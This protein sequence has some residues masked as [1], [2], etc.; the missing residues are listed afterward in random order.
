MFHFPPRH[1]RRRRWLR[2]LAWIA[3]IAVVV[4]A[5]L[6]VALWL[7]VRSQWFHRKMV[8][9]AGQQASAALHTRVQLRNYNLHFSLTAPSLD[10]Y[11]ITVAGAPPYPSPPLLRI[12]HLHVGLQILSLL[13]RQWK[14]NDVV[15]DR[16]VAHVFFAASGANNLPNFSSGKSS[17]GS[18]NIFQMGIRRAAV[19]QGVVWYNNRAQLLSARLQGVS[20]QAAFQPARRAYAGSFGYRSGVL[21]YGA[22]RPLASNLAVQFD[23]T[24]ARLKLMP[25]TLASPVLQLRLAATLRNYA[26]PAVAGVYRLQLNAG[27]LRSTLRNS[28]LPSGAVTLAG[29]LDYA[30]RPGRSLWQSLRVIGS[31][32]SPALIE[33]ADGKRIALRRLR[34]RYRLVNDN[35]ELSGLHARLLGGTLDARLRMLKLGSRRG[36]G[37]ATLRARGQQ[38]GRLLTTAAGPRAN[39]VA[40]ARLRGS[41]ALQAVADWRGRFHDL[42]ARLDAGLRASLLNPAAGARGAASLAPVTASLHARYD[43]RRR[44]L[45][46]SRSYLD[47]PGNVLRAAGV[48]GLNRG[49]AAHM[50]IAFNS[51][52]LHEL[53]TLASLLRQA[54]G[55]PQPAPLGLYGQARFAGSIAGTLSRPRLSGSLAASRLRLRGTAWRTLAASIYASPSRLQISRARLVAAGPGRLDFSIAAGL[56]QWG[57]SASSP[58]QANLSAAQFQLASLARLAGFS[59]PL[60]GN[61][62]ARLAVRGSLRNPVGSGTIGVTAGA[63]KTSRLREPIQQLQVA[64]QGDGARVT[65]RARLRMAA[66]VADLTGEYRPHRQTYSVV[67]SANRFDLAKLHAA[68]GLGLAGVVNLNGAGQG[69]VANPEFHA[70][71]SAPG[72]AVAH[73]AI[74]PLTLQAS[75]ANHVLQAALDARA[76]GAWMRGRL[77]LSLLGNEPLTAGLDTQTVPLGP[78]IA[79]YSA[80]LAGSV[81]GVTEIHASLAGPL[82]QPEKM[83]AQVAIPVF[84]L[85]YRNRV[86]LA[87]AAPLRASLAHGRLTIESAHLE[88]TGTNLELNGSMPLKG[89]SGMAMRLIGA[90]DLRVAEIVDPALIG[91]GGLQLALD[92]GGSLASPKLGG[93]IRIVD[94]ALRTNSMPLGLAHA[95]GVLT[96][97]PHRLIVSSFRGDVGGGQLTASGGLTYRPALYLDLGMAGSYIS[98]L[99]PR[100]LRETF[101]GNLSLTGNLQAAMLAGQIKVYRI[102]ATPQFDLTTL[103]GQVGGSSAPSPPGSFSQ[104]L[105]LD[106]R[107]TTP[108]GIGTSTPAFSMAGDANLMIQGTA[109]DPVV[110]GRMNINRGD[111]LFNGNRFLLQS[112]TLM[113]A[114][115]TRTVPTV[116]LSAD[117]TIQQYKLHLRFQG[118]ADQLRTQYTSSP[119]L[120][121][122]DI[123]NLLAFGQTTEASAANPTPG[124]LG[125]ENMLAS[126]VA[127]QVT[128]R[129][130]K[131]AGISQLSVD[132]ILGGNGQNP[133]ARVNIRQRVTGNLYITLS[134]DVTSTQSDMIEI[135]YNFTPKKSVDVVRDQNGGFHINTRFKK[136]W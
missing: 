107:V 53:E 82:Q 42:R 66:G 7:V 133:G 100:E 91:S 130:Q 23:A 44:Q 4:I 59:I 25:L 122:A 15:V 49:R 124:S 115:P 40:Q 110:L 16:P 67:L 113:F 73:Q 5:A 12:A 30:S 76:E 125:A 120:P 85:N 131:I 63:I 72:L 10:V 18:S 62:N 65:A 2:I 21:Q 24:A 22:Y 39:R 78:L 94:A 38:L 104:N 14:L 112:G 70:S 50:T 34:G 127:S 114:N 128:G 27:R 35:F 105:Q 126:S 77:R 119:P 51:T 135:Q 33:R 52:N 83:Q 74:A 47:L 32:A 90:L 96:L 92:A 57:V 117:T 45:A 61:L 75:L 103:A 68:R 55:K 95:N 60:T 93:N 97:T 111:M 43:A 11:R 98:L 56:R 109:S 81:Q 9:Y 54:P 99:Y 46:L 6:G 29:T 58:I 123:I 41:A 106:I 86:Q 102:T 69:T 108:N 80:S 13:R 26:R 48:L 3:G 71:L 89:N 134:T 79:A 28:S 101:G 20:F 36:P 84:R 1:P 31:L 87:A 129:V 37:S 64:F 118:P 132:P 121:P 136:S 116:N 19:N 8:S 88:G 17:S